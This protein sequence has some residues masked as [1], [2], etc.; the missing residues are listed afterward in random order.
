MTYR[1]GA[2]SSS[3][4]PR[5]YRIDDEV[6]DFVRRD[7]INRFRH[8]LEEKKLWDAAREERLQEEVR[9]EILSAVEEA[10]KFGPPPVETMFEEVFA[11]MTPQLEEQK[12]YLVDYLK[13]HPEA[14]EVK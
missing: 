12:D 10:E 3:D 2:H 14:W 13:R 1:Q 7:P 6:A 9:E 8:Y 5:A 4:D 11:Q